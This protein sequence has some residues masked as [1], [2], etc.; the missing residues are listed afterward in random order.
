VVK[1]DSTV[2]EYMRD[3]EPL[4]LLDTNVAIG[5]GAEYA[6][7]AMEAGLTAL[8]AVKVSARRDPATAAPFHTLELSQ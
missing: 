3:L 4:V 1:P 6:I 2:I 7:G 5:S 8:E